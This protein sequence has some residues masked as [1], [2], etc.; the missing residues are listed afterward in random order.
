[1]KRNNLVLSLIVLLV[2]TATAQG[3]RVVRKGMKSG[4]ITA[5]EVRAPYYSLEMLQGKWLEWK[6]IDVS[7]REKVRFTDSLM[8]TFNKRD[9]VQVRDGVSMA[10]AGQASIIKPNEL[11]L[12]GDSYTIE[13]MNGINLVINDGAFIRT[14][15]KTKAFYFDSYGNKKI[16]AEE[17]KF[18][19]KASLSN[20]TGDWDVYRRQAEPG[21][22]KDHESQLIKRIFIPVLDEYG[23]GIGNI[24]YF[25]TSETEKVSCSIKVSGSAMHIEAGKTSW[26]FNIYKASGSEFIF[27]KPG[28]LMYFAKKL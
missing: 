22:A 18:P 12:A 8:L 13:S 4:K 11:I 24:S 6:R 10:M 20:L 17:Y 26:D 25:E 16:L 23:M 3:Q 2:T 27:G 5:K 7:N 19:V 14:L 15:K 9:S 28:G 21:F 1:M